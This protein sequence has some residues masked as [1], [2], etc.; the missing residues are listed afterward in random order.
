[1]ND[2]SWLPLKAP[3]T[4]R[5]FHPALNVATE[6]SCRLKL[7]FSIYFDGTRNSKDVDT[8]SRTHSNIAKPFS[9]A[10]NNA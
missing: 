4:T 9:H 3:P 5:I 1:M 2:I 6:S 8:A 7:Q 10:E